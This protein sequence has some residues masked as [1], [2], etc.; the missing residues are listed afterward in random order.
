VSWPYLPDECPRCHYFV[1]VDEPCSDDSGYEIPGIC[2]HPLIAMELFVTR[3][4]LARRLAHCRF[5]APTSEPP[6]HVTQQR[7][8][9][10]G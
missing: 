4:G 10:P 1:A 2:A 7:S 8:A 3:E 9:H 5:F 6:T